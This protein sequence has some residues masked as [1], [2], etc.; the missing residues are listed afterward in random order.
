LKSVKVLVIEDDRLTQLYYASILENLNITAV[1]CLTYENALVEMVKE[2]YDLILSDVKLKD[3]NGIDLLRHF[4]KE[5]QNRIPF[6]VFSG[7]TKSELIELYGQFNASA[8]L[9]KP[10]GVQELTKV[11]RELLNLKSPSCAKN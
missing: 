9:T 2:D 1:A 7:Y 11:I 3:G 6:V 8:V 5:T 10:L 4:D